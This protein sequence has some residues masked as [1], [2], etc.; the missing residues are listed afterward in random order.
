MTDNNFLPIY[1]FKHQ[2]MAT[3]FVSEKAIL[4]FADGVLAKSYSHKCF[5]EKMLTARIYIG[6]NHYLG[7]H[8]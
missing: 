2:V 4:D 1:A 3:V 5:E 8:Q 7:S 6:W